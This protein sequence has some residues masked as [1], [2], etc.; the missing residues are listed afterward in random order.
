MGEVDLFNGASLI[1]VSIFARNHEPLVR[2]GLTGAVNFDK[3][4][5]RA[6]V[7]PYFRCSIYKRPVILSRSIAVGIFKRRHYVQ[8]PRGT[9][10]EIRSSAANAKPGSAGNQFR[11]V[12][13]LSVERADHPI[14][15]SRASLHHFELGIERK[16]HPCIF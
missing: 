15:F 14:I 5:G 1:T 13:L 4:R 8:T 9:S 2:Y 12:L 3:A 7:R 11:A 6:A 16:S 10:G